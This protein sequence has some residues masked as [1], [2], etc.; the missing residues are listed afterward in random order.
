MQLHKVV[1]VQFLSS[2]PNQVSIFYCKIY[3]KESWKPTHWKNNMF[4]SSF[5][6]KNQNSLLKQNKNIA[7][8]SN[9]YDQTIFH[10]IIISSSMFS[11]STIQKS[12]FVPPLIA[13]ILN[14]QLCIST[15]QPKLLTTIA[16]WIQ[17]W[18]KKKKILKPPKRGE[19]KKHS[20]TF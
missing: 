9:L 6:H 5:T 4:F 19:G 20:I 17:H 18:K 1:K 11:P 10:K 8:L 14:H 16:N 13:F 7:S 3:C 2:Y 15:N 12:T